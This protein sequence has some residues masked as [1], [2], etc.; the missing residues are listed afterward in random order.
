LSGVMLPLVIEASIWLSVI[1]CARA[2]RSHNRAGLRRLQW[3]GS[4]VR[5]HRYAGRA[6]RPPRRW[7]GRRLPFQHHRTGPAPSG[8]NATIRPCCAFLSPLLRILFVIGLMSSRGFVLAVEREGGERCVWAIWSGPSPLS[9]RR[10]A[11]RARFARRSGELHL[12]GQGGTA[13]GQ[14]LRTLTG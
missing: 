13:R 1:P 5:R 14:L 3:P 6:G 11:S 9:D 10:A 2:L 7:P 4:L 12:L 8:T